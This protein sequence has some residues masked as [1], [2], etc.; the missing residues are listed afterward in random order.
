MIIN[1]QKFVENGKPAWEELEALLARRE[2]GPEKRL[3]LEEIRRFHYLYDRVSSDL[4]KVATF[5]SEKE[6][7]RYLET[8]VARAY[9]QIH[10]IRETPHR[11][12]PARWFFVVF[13]RTFRRHLRAF[14]LASA[15]T[16]AGC[17]FGAAAMALDPD[18]KDVLLP[19]ADHIMRDPA[20]RVADEERVLTDRL[21]GRKTQGAAFYM[22][23][24]SRVAVATLALGVT[25]GIGTL[26]ALF[27]N[28]V[29]VGAI[30]LDYAR[31]GQTD[32]LVG[33]LL[34]HGS[35]EIPAILLAGQAG[36]VLA[37]ALIGWG[38]NISLRARMR[39]VSRDLVTLIF[40]VVVLLVWAGI[41]EA[42]LS[43]Y[44]KPAIPYSL[45][46]VFGCVE[47]ALVIVF[48]AWSGRLAGRSAR[49]VGEVTTPPANPGAPP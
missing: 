30:T 19:S 17:L 2:R 34:P 8:L 14:A 42:Y 35:V 16:A 11:F 20:D 25:W 39:Q 5:A 38:R 46:I 9:G 45:K 28:G 3:S 47:L 24:N 27:A 49:L 36:F 37:S 10:E 12:R 6:T 32:F 43:Q 41:V 26:V 40:G 48:L 18:S 13:P 7:R 22:T 1:I 15:V 29:M 21:N 44:H 23:H 33:W 4:A 31:A